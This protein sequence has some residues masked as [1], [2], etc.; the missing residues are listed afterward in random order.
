MV[1]HV[2]EL[3]LQVTK[4]GASGG[5]VV[6]VVAVFCQVEEGRSFKRLVACQEPNPWLDNE[7]SP[8]WRYLIG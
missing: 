1:A 4:K 6:V 5:S 7:S 2:G 8:T 3:S